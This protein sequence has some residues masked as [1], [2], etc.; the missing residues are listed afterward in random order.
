M[1]LLPLGDKA[2]ILMDTPWGYIN[3]QFLL[4]YTVT[5]K[6]LNNL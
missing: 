6:L 5:E 4:L 1:P 3:A 2:D